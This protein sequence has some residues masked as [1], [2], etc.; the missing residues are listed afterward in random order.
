MM[1]DALLQDVQY[2]IRGMKRRPAYTLMI[3]TTLALGIGAN[4]TMFGIL[5][6]LLL[7]A[8]AQ[9]ADPDRLVLFQTRTLGYQGYQTTQGY[10]ARTVLARGVSDFA[11]VAVATPTAVVQRK[12]YTSGRGE[13]ATRVA[14][15]LVSAN[16]FRT[17]GVHPALGRFF[18]NSDDDEATV[19][20]VAV[21]GYGFWKR[22]YA[23]SNDAIGRTIDVG[24]QRY[25]IIGVAPQGFTGTEMRDVDVWLPIAA[26]ADL[27][28]E[29]GPDWTTTPSSQW[30][31]VLAR[32]KP[33]VA[34]EHATAQATTVYR[35]WSRERLKDATAAKLA[36]IDSQ[37]VVLGSIIPGRSHWSWGMSGSGNEVKISELLSAVAAMV[38]LI[39]CANVANLLLVRAFGRRRE[40]A[41][42]LALGVSRRR[43][44]TQLL[45]EGMLLA[46]LGAAGALAVTAFGSQFIRR[47]MIGDGAWSG[48]AVSGRVLA[49][50]AVVA[51]VTGLVTS[52][53]PALQSSNPDL[54][55]ALKAGARE[56]SVHKSR[57]RTGLLVAQAALAIVLLAGAG[58]FIRSLRNVAALDL[59]VDTNRVLVAQIAHE[60]MG[61]SGEEGLA[62]FQ[63]FV[64]K[65]KTVPGVRSAAVTLGLPFQLSWGVTTNVPGVAPATKL[66]VVQ[67]GVTPEY[68]DALNIPRVA[69]RTFTDADRPG[70]ENVAVINDVL[71]KQ[72]WPGQSPIGAC[73]K[74]GEDTVPCTTIVGVVRGTRRQDLIE[75]P[76]G[77]VYRP[78]VQ[79]PF[80]SMA[81]TVSFFGYTLVVGTRGEADLLAEPVRRAIQSTRPSVTYAN[82]IP[83]HVLFA[84]KTRGWELGARVFTAFGALALLLA[85]IGLFSVVAFTI[86]QRM[87]E[88]GVRTAL[89]ARPSDLL[90]LTLTRGLMP[91]LAGIVTGVALALGGGRLISSMLF[92][93]APSDPTVLFGASIVLLVCAV[94]A[95]LVP[96]MRAA[97]VDPTIALRAD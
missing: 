75:K 52:L 73:V 42:R 4:A 36:R 5:D 95:S 84:G 16:Y 93:V 81:S 69:G 44:M 70:G 40:I 51:L 1:T 21:I 86:G 46:L 64:A 13:S 65:V 58:L 68:F 94:A 33:G 29:K 9:I 24:V 35:N 18:A 82:V 89:G 53:V 2:A 14:G 88:F 96:A 62:L 19:Q 85:G 30:L 54:T 45:I 59:G 91:V 76:V 25:T 87:H 6:R 90:M 57:M 43:L 23:A 11:D 63:E 26:A 32:V 28:L 34:I 97:R 92:N 72:Y 41:V 27:R 79:I 49:F 83:M 60:S 3:A 47:W 39:A 20:R 66:Q 38:L 55:S 10:A 12:Y 7:Q 15:S 17:L 80:A 31:L 48:N 37:V 56:G 8:P 67:Y 77:Q 74:L 61:L 78:L 50:T 71:A 22:Q